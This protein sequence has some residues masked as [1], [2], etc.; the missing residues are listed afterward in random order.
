MVRSAYVSFYN[1]P[2]STGR[3]EAFHFFD[4]SRKWGLVHH[5]FIGSSSQFDMNVDKLGTD[6]LFGHT[7]V[8]IS[9]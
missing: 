9:S 8:S 7:R 4:I 2:V 5:W 6:G 3:V 1:L